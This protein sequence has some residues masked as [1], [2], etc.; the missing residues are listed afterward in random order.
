MRKLMAMA[1]VALG[2]FA[3]RAEDSY[4]Y[5]MIDTTDGRAEKIT[6]DAVQVRAFETSAGVD[7]AGTYLTLYYGNGNEAGMS[8]SPGAATSGL[9]LYASLASSA[10]S[11]Y[12]YVVELFHDGTKVG[13][14]TSLVFTEAMAQSFVS[15]MTPTGGFPGLSVW[16]AGSFGA[17]PEPNSALLVLVG[18]ALLG[19]R[20]KRIGASS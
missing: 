3:V 8:V 1:I 13:Q 18:C 17:V 6:Y 9:A 12:S 11:A 10:G 20:R 19:L 5:W 14:S 7:S 16:A 2:A 15:T 4:L